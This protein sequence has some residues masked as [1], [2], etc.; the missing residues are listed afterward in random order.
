MSAPVPI[1]VVSL[2]RATERRARIS[3]AFAD[4]GLD[5]ELCDAVD[6]QA[7]APVDVAEYSRW[8]SLYQVGRRLSLGEIGCARSHL[9]LYQRMLDDDVDAA[10]IVEDDAEPS[11]ELP[12]VLADI[13]RLPPDWQVVNLHS[14]FASAGSQP[15]GDVTLGQASQLCTYRRKPYGTVSYL[16]R[17]SGAQRLVAVGAP[18]RLPADELLFRHRSA[19]LITYGIEPSPVAH[20]GVPEGP[21]G[22]DSLVLPRAHETLDPS[23]P[24]ERVVAA[25]GKVRRQVSTRATR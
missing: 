7:P 8:R 4:L 11:P 6:G 14:T 2:A 24:A 22:F 18:V 16:L 3:R 25:L 15:Y 10:C 13:D 21:D 23:T 9:R 5:L 20:I 17:R 19:G 1:W 12:A